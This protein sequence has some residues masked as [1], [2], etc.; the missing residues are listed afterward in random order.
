[1]VK[2]CVGGGVY[3]TGEDNLVCIPGGIQIIQTLGALF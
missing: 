3:S 2:V 1:V